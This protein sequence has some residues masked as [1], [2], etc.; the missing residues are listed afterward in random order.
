MIVTELAVRAVDVPMRRPLG[1]SARS[2]TSAPLLL[3]DL[4][5]D[6]GLTGRAYLFC[7][8][9]AG[10]RL[11]A[12]V[13]HDARDLVVGET[14][15]PRSSAAAL[16]RRWRLFGNAGAVAM[17]LAGVDVAAWDAL[18]QEAGVPLVTLL[19]GQSRALPCYNSNGL[20][21]IGAAAAA[22]EAT[23]LREE[24]YSQLKLR[25][26]YPSLE[27]DVEV[28]RAVRDAVA[29]AIV[30]VDYNQKLD[31]DEALRRCVAIDRE[32]VGWIEEPLAHDDFIGS[33]EVAERVAC[34]I[35]IGENLAGPR[36]VELALRVHASDLLM[37]D[38][39]RIGGVTGWMQA[40]QLTADAAIPVSSHL[41]PEV[42]VHL[43][44]A[45]R[46]ADRLEMVDWAAPLLLEPLRVVDG[47]AVPSS[48][49]GT[50]VVW[51][52]DVV[53]AYLC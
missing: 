27:E 22:A 37:F 30:L 47:F 14:V 15:E 46:A 9:G 4:H 16:A 28:L 43:L 34:P 2:L 38:L 32:G 18:A 45:S 36:A 39:Q 12:D 41:F 33:A 42:S 24:G 35:Q 5:T 6:V 13:L 52:E 8:D 17:S 10:Q 29:D 26:G 44:A 25:L 20:G 48:A 49:P 23:E 50:G 19:G 21:L 53:R 11:M 31:R 3:L 7:Y 40:Q 1:T 51:N